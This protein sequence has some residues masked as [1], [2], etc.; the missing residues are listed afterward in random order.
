MKQKHSFNKRFW[1]FFD[2]TLSSGITS[3]I[4]WL[5]IA[6][7]LIIM[8]ATLI[9][10]VF[11]I[12]QADNTQPSFGETFWMSMMRVIDAGNV[13]G[14]TGWIF[15]IVMLVVTM[16]GI[17]VFSVLVGILTSAIQDKIF[18][19]RKG[20]STVLEENHIVILG[21]SSKIMPIL[22]E[23]IIA[24]ETLQNACI[25]VMAEKDKVEME[26][27]IRSKIN[28]SHKAR[29]ICRT[30]NTIDPGDLKIAS[31]DT[32]RSI[33][34]L[35][36]ENEMADMFVIKTMLALVGN[37]ERKKEPY[38]IVAEIAEEDKL[39]IAKMVGKEEAVYVYPSDLIAKI[40]LQSC[41]HS[42]LSVI[43]Q[44]LL[45]FHGVEIYFFHEKELVGKTFRDAMFAYDDS[46]VIGLCH[47]AEG[48]ELNP[49]L[50]TII[51]AAD[52]LIVIA[53]DDYSIHCLSGVNHNINKDV[54]VFSP[55]PPQ[56]LE[57]TLVL[58]WNKKGNSIIQQIDKFV[59]PGSEITVVS[60]FNQAEKDYEK[61][62]E[63]SLNQKINFITADTT[64]K[65]LLTN[66]NI[67]SFNHVILLSYSDKL[68]IQEADANTLITLLYLRQIAEKCNYSFGI[69]S[70]MIDAKN[71]QLMVNTQADDF[72]VSNRLVS[73]MIAQLAEN[74]TLK[75]VF[76][77]LFD[78]AG[79]E[80][81]L[82]P[83]I[84][85]VK[86]NTPVNFYTV[87]QS[88]IGHNEIAIGYRIHT[89]YN[90]AAK[91]YGVVLNPVKSHL[92]TFSE[93]DKIIVIA[94]D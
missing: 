5:G 85:Y 40:I 39:E 73:L 17:F 84:N 37:P 65:R 60:Q 31:V 47:G 56:E 87:T 1:Y 16:A 48:I 9:I 75:Y 15:R 71:R 25:V 4:G 77:D 23:L 46:I 51:T 35:S 7:L 8:A 30:G 42:G 12:S 22:S 45:S 21:W 78:V 94:K 93:H 69:V 11:H 57:R 3:L 50:E 80:I 62:S 67:P 49:D 26:D 89:F 41:R 54:I 33:I 32:A 28:F 20:R 53:E 43:Y 10:V 63:I 38:H 88:A 2:N 68:S 36:P 13:A 83:A 91:D 58:G 74:K 6:S 92:T 34:I 14:D 72:I 44:N 70:E 76:D 90:D 27:E 52:R 24:D 18:E 64:D 61:I 79:S 81:Y 66:L 55:K 86:A 59:R 29:I 19:L 82:R